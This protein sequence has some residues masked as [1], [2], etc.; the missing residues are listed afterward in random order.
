MVCLSSKAELA[1]ICPETDRLAFIKLYQL[2]AKVFSI[3]RER[4]VDFWGRGYEGIIRLTLPSCSDA[5][6][7]YSLS[8]ESVVIVTGNNAWFGSALSEVVDKMDADIDLWYEKNSN[9][10]SNISD[11]IGD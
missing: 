1:T 2:Q 9:Q 3:L 4:L 6:C 11:S 7:G 5:Q 10:Q 8:L